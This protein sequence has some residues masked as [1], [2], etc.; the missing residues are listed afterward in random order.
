M[1]HAPLLWTT[2]ASVVVVGAD[3][4]H[5]AFAAAAGLTGLCLVVFGLRILIHTAQWLRW[6][7]HL[8]AFEIRIPRTATVEDVARW[9]G[10][11][12]AVLRA[13]RWWSWLP[14]WPMGVETTAT[15]HG[16]RH[17][18]IAPRRLYAAVLSTLSAALPGARLDEATHYLTGE[19][20][21]RFQVATEERLV[22]LGD[23]LA[24]DRA[25]Q[26][27]R[28]FLAALQPLQPGELVRVQWL[29]TGARAPRWIV[30]PHTEARML[31]ARWKH[32]DPVLLAVCRLGVS[33]G[34]GKERAK[35]VHGRAW[36]ALGGL[37]TPRA[38]IARRRLIPSFMAAARLVLRVYPRGRWPMVM[39][40]TEVGGLLSLVAGPNALPG[41]PNG[42]SRTLPPLSSMPKTGI[43]I[44]RSNYPGV[45]TM[46]RLTASDRLRHVWMIG[47]TGAGKS[48]LLANMIGHDIHHGD[49]LVVIDA[50]GDLVTDVLNRV[51]DSRA[52]DVIVIDP[53]SSDHA[54]GI[55]PLQAGPPEQ[56]AGF[57]YHVLHAVYAR[58]WGPRTA[59]IVRGCLLTLTTTKSSDGDHYTLLEIPELLTNAKFRRLVTSR[60]LPSQ[61]AS[62]WRWYD[63]MPATQ[64]S[65]VIS[66]V[67][68]KLR[69]FTLSTPLRA[70]LGQSIGIDFAQVMANKRIVLVALK[71]GLLGSEVSGLIGSLVMASV[72]Q[73]VLSR[74]NLPADRRRPRWL[75]ID[76]FQDL[77][78]LPLDLADMCAQA[79]GLGLGMVLAH[80]FL[81][82][83]TP[84]LKASITGTV[85]S[86]LVFQLGHGD[87]KHLAPAFEPLSTDD[88]RHLGAYEIALRPCVDGATQ[89]PITGIT[90]PLPQPTRDGTALATVSRRRYGMPRDQINDQI[91]ARAQGTETATQVRIGR[92]TNNGGE[93]P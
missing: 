16:I 83:L 52:D 61:L 49:G 35:A 72:W 12:R 54:V 66:P 27:G 67:L 5:L 59:D 77:V 9:V 86:H 75:Y 29:L 43:V 13:R 14:R 46:L 11:L 51:P 18:L 70:L 26:A 62:F 1:R 91:T 78:K 88:L 64:Q 34:L 38:R 68:N 55:N 15:R 17:V 22:S 33:S 7:H 20:D 84:E 79:R 92:T 36:A 4:L 45:Q 41:T 76:E 37:N 47:P 48:T 23:L 25:E 58:S 8:V 90:Y 81:D 30:S 69:A 42:I 60:P 87:A 6:Q 10:T 3:F 82:Q 71:K 44:A 50:R 32:G 85:R 28:H 21:P 89:R 39:T 53:T 31:P 80:Q 40:A 2:R 63:S 74:A 57:I 24:L 73:A 56:A 93:T 19:K 65:T